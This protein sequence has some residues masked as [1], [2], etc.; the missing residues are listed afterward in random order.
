MMLSHEVTISVYQLK[1]ECSLEDADSD[2]HLYL[3]NLFRYVTLVID[4][5]TTIYL[6]VELILK[7]R[8]YANARLMFKFF[9]SPTHIFEVIILLVLTVS[10]VLQIIEMS[11]SSNLVTRE[12]N[13]LLISLVRVPRPLLLVR[14]YWM[15]ESQ[16]QLPQ[17][18]KEN[19][20]K[21]M[22]K[23]GEITLCMFYCLLIFALIGGQLFGE[24]DFF[25]VKNDKTVTNV[26]YRDLTYPIQRCPFTGEGR[27]GCP[28]S[29][30]CTKLNFE[31][32]GTN[33][34]YFNHKLHSF[35]AVYEAMSLEGWSFK[36]LAVMES[37]P[38]GVT[39]SFIYY[40]L[41]VIISGILGRNIFIAI[42]T[43]V[44][45]DLR[46]E[47]EKLA[48]RYGSTQKTDKEDLKILRRFSGKSLKLVSEEHGVHHH[49]SKLRWYE[50]ILHS[51]RGYST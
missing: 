44:F 6:L 10:T 35:K 41:L 47:Y 23:V 22:M 33:V 42:T 17:Y 19:M 12:S 50:I 16:F 29:F 45:A 25:C 36:M 18:I 8:L 2:D 34:K 51:K 43:G 40:L 30:R 7:T 15:S 11:A 31:D 20:K 46:V 4:V 38:E 9:S 13:Y 24:M 49:H 5:L 48:L 28:K 1:V 21:N 14:A 39:V 32:R 3:L 37:I 26:T 27:R